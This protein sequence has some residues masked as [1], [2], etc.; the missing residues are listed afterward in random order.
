MWE[1]PL[2]R[3]DRP[4][5]PTLQRPSGGLSGRAIGTP[6]IRR[7][8]VRETA[9][10]LPSMTELRPSARR[11]VQRLAIGFDQL[12]TDHPFSSAISWWAGAV[13]AFDSPMPTPSCRPSDRYPL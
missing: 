9:A 11:C 5:I 10:H 2:I 4:S 6:S 8:S 12:L 3:A 1:R 13:N 7:H